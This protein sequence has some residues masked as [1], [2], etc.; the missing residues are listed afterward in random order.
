MAHC[1][2]IGGSGFIGTE[3]TR[4]LLESGREVISLGRQKAH[5][6]QEALGLTHVQG[7]YSDLD[8]LRDLMG[9][10]CDVINLAY[11]TVPKTSF[12]D[13][14]FDLLS[15][16]PANVA[17]LQEACRA[18]VNRLLIV[19]SGGTVY[20][21]AQSLPISE[22][23]PTNPI[24]P[25]GITK[26]TID[27]YARMFYRTNDLPVVV[28]RP[29]NAYGPLQRTGVGQG[30]IAAA[31]S[32][33]QNRQDVQLYGAHGTVR[34]Y[35]HVDDVASGII[36]AL[37]RGKD[38]ELY[39]LG[40]GVGASNL[41]I[42]KHLKGMAARD[43]FDVTVKHMPERRFDVKANILDASKLQSHTNWRSSILLETGLDTAWQHTMDRIRNQGQHPDGP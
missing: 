10:G 9:G 41:D 29:A 39:N 18:G 2:V 20:G 38:G 8:L 17:L 40:T 26:L 6:R 33:I 35:I 7:D 16:L 28:V 36:A 23:H 19:S 12:G 30:F 25:Y 22:D 1:L 31:I 5:P 43:G 15:N 3:V 42:V 37:E 11:S 34:D 21:D 14:T 13:P 4:R 32:A 24:S 27:S